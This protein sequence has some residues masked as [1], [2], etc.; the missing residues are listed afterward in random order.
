MMTETQKLGNPGS[1]L[2]VW[3]YDDLEGGTASW[4]NY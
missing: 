1:R 4:P 3:A 2:S